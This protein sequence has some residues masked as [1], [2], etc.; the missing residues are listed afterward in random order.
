M[1]S[2]VQ[3]S[4]PILP[5]GRHTRTSTSAAAWW[6]GA[7]ITPIEDITTS[8][9]SDSNG[10]CSASPVTHTALQWLM[11]AR[12]RC[13]RLPDARLWIEAYTLGAVC[14][15]AVEHAAAGRRDREPRAVEQ[16][17][18]SRTAGLSQRSRNR[19]FGQPAVPRHASRR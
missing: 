6:Y 19:S 17:R 15:L 9:D 12:T 13:V 4:S 18:G 8:K 3:L 5:P 7:N 16:A 10:R 11:E 2:G 1:P 14:S